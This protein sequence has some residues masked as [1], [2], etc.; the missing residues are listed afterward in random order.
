MKLLIIRLIIT[1]SVPIVVGAAIVLLIFYQS[2]WSAL[3][4]WEDDSVKWINQTQQ[5]I[6]HNSAYSQQLIETYSFNQL[7]LHLVVMNS[8]IQKYYSSELIINP[9]AQF[10]KCSYRE[11]IFNECPPDVYTKLNQ[12]IFYV[13]LYY[14]REGFNFNKLTTQQQEFIV[15]NEFVSYYGRAAILASI[16][17]EFLKIQTL[18]NADTTSIMAHQPS[19]YQNFTA[20]TYQ[21][22]LGTD[23]IEPY[24]PRCRPWYK[25]A[26]QHEGYFFYEPYLDAI[27]GNLE[28]TL[29]SRI[30]HN[31]EFKSVSSI[32]YEMN[33]IIQLFKATQSQ[34]AY[35]VLFHEFN[36]TIFYHPQLNASDV[37]SWGDLEFKNITDNCFGDQALELCNLEKNN[38]V[39]QLDQTVNFI[40][41]LNYSIENQ[42]NTD[43]LYQYWSRYGVNLISLVY[44]IRS[45]ITKYPTQQPYSF[46]IILTARVLVDNSDSLKLFNVLNANLIKIPL[47]VEFVALSCLIFVF[48]INYGH[49]QIYQIQYPIELLII[50][51]QKS[52]M[53]QQQYKNPVNMKSETND[54]VKLN[55]FTKYLNT[56]NTPKLNQNQSKIISNQRNKNIS[57]ELSYSM[58]FQNNT[59]QIFTFQQHDKQ[60]IQ[61]DQSGTNFR[62]KILNQDEI[63]ETPSK[64]NQSLF[65]KDSF[66]ESRVLTQQ[67]NNSNY[68]FIHRSNSNYN[69][70]HR[71]NSNKNRDYMNDSINR[72]QQDLI[73]Q[74]MTESYL[75]TRSTN[76][77]R[78]T[79]D[80]D[81]LTQLEQIQ[82]KE[83]GQSKILSGLKPL[84]L[85]M[86]IIKKTFQMLEEVINYQ[87]QAYSQDEQDTMKTLFHFSKAKSTF[88]NLQNL[89]GLS[90]CYFNLGII[91]L[92]KNEYEQSCEYF[93]ASVT[94][95]LQL[96]GIDCLDQINENM[97][98]NIQDDQKDQLFIFCKRILSYAHSI[99]QQSLELAQEE[100]QQ[101]QQQQ[102]INQ[103]NKKSS[104][105]YLMLRSIR[106]FKVVQKI[107]YNCYQKSPFQD[108][109]LIFLYQEMIEMFIYLQQTHEVDQYF[110]KSNAL[111]EVN[112]YKLEL[113]NNNTKDKKYLEQLKTKNIILE[114]LK[115]KQKFLSGIIEKQNKNY[116]Q[117]LEYFTQS[118]EY[119]TH[120]NPF[121]RQKVI[122]NIKLL[123][124]ELQLQGKVIDEQFD[125][126]DSNTPI[127]LV[128]AIQLNSMSSFIIAE[129]CLENIKKSNFFKK[130]D[131]IQIVIFNQELDVLLPYT[132]IKSDY[133]YQLMISSIQKIG[134]KTT[135]NQNLNLKKLDYIQAINQTLDHV[136]EF[137]ESQ[138]VQLEEIYKLNIKYNKNKEDS[139]S[140]QLQKHYQI[141]K[142]NDLNQRKKIIILQSSD[143]F[144]QNDL[145]I[146]K[147]FIK[148]QKILKLEKPTVFHLIDYQSIIDKKQ[149]KP[150][151]SDFIEY[152][153]FYE[154]NKLITKLNKLRNSEMLN[155]EYEFMTILN[156]Y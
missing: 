81:F 101:K 104:I 99:K 138:L 42:I 118:L 131:R 3:Y 152:Q 88:Q 97:F 17:E 41:T 151:Q 47:I 4:T 137:K 94:Q 69:F 49:F 68:N 60:A 33:S 135:L 150:F 63:Q 62:G 127:D 144:T 53:E 11:L 75:I 105:K 134:L 98:V 76:A 102:V 93:E 70:L 78:I 112:L 57:Q 115:T 18:Y 19:R 73:N 21:T 139:F 15:M 122:Q 141:I 136:Y 45:Q 125:D 85:E 83:N 8:I 110:D 14:I 39:Q 119:G 91:Y 132:Q 149:G 29:S 52:L 71:S 84:F 154:E 89:T 24:D 130:N 55:L 48:I 35:S 13:D 72:S 5:Q 123:F 27:E 86:K 37:I 87:I 10:L 103:L 143:Q 155:P 44:P 58:S 74:P 148:L 38:F 67:Q 82:E 1:V 6:L 51:L 128:Y 133:Q 46:S 145:T 36:N 129:S 79:Q 95:S 111:L 124:D 126:F 117:A 34:N 96:I 43:G 9:N 116:K 54:K 61:L 50:F 56:G 20:S 114:L 59:K 121:F 142:Q 16:S 12:S 100:L 26:K 22:C 2:L 25:Y 113:N 153:S 40:Q 156:N 7:Q 109:F 147:S 23:F 77:T 92:L 31:S 90:R 108:I 30:Y 146:K 65:K 120:F 32:D 107:T 66:N 64:I 106:L 140:Q 28:M 80:F